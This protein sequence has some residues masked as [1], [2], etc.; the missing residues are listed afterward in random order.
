MTI[1][2][3]NECSAEVSDKADFC[4]G[5]G[6]KRNKPKGSGCGTVIYF[7]IFIP[8]IFYILSNFNSYNLSSSA[9]NPEP[10]E[11]NDLKLG[12][13]DQVVVSIGSQWKYYKGKDL[14]SKGTIYYSEVKST[15]A[16]NFDFPYS[17]AQHG[18]LTLRTHPRYGKDLMLSIDKGQFL[19]RSYNGCKVLV[20]FD[21]ADAVSYSAAKPQDH[22]S[23]IIF[24]KNYSKFAGSMLKAK[25]VRISADVFQEGSPVFEFNVDG[26][27]VSKY[28]PK[29]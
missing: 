23:N 19:C 17:G 25:K 26:F 27:D 11:E 16:V 22:S 3:C 21:E 9:S 2:K 24:I 14:M 8:F 18:I 15:N 20:R 7:I 10:Q 29:G 4:P 1:I 13:D 5:C 6:A 12:E 28:R